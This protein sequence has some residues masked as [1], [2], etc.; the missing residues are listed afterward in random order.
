MFVLAPAQEGRHNSRYRSHGHTMAV[1]PWGRV[2]A[3]RAAG[4]GLAWADIDLGVLH[5]VR[6][7]LPMG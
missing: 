4:V 1:D 6:A 3:E 7:K 2:L 5:D